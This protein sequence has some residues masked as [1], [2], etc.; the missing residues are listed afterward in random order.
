MPEE[1]ATADKNGIILELY[2]F[3]EE[4]TSIFFNYL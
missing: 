3:S 2:T 1:N 4:T